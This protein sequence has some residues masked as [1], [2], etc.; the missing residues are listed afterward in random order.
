[1][2][3]RDAKVDGYIFVVLPDHITS[4]EKIYGTSN[5]YEFQLYCS[6]YLQVA[7]ERMSPVID[8]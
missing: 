6:K 1:M 2:V 7:H 8:M 4:S 5:Y 3:V